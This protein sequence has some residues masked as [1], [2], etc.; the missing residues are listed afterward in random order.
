MLVAKE[1][2][3][4]ADYGLMDVGANKQRWQKNNDNYYKGP[5]NGRVSTPNCRFALREFF[6]GT[7]I[8]AKTSLRDT[9]HRDC[10]S[11]DQWHAIG[12]ARFRTSVP[13]TPATSYL[14]VAE[15]KTLY[16]DYFLVDAGANKLRW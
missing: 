8:Q 10:P 11:R 2:P 16:A 15:E 7:P 4:Y 5:K 9:E 14:T 13:D 3:L 1:K 12:N 6:T